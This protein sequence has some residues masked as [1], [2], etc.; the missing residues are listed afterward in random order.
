M[1][2]VNL[3]LLLFILLFLN[4]GCGSSTL[5]NTTK[6]ITSSS[7][8]N[9]I[10]S[11]ITIVENKKLYKGVYQDNYGIKYFDES[12]SIN[13]MILPVSPDFGEVIHTLSPNQIKIAFS[14]YDTINKET[15]LYV[16]DLYDKKLVWL[17]NNSGYFQVNV[18]W[19]ND[20]LLYCNFCSFDK[21]SES[22]LWTNLNGYTEL[23]N[24]NQNKVVKKIKPKKGGLLEEYIQKKYFVYSDY[25]G[26]YLIDKNKN[27][28]L[29]SW[30]NITTKNKKDIKY[31]P[32]GKKLFYIEK[33]KVIDQYGN[34]NYRNELILSNYDGSK[35]KIIIGYRYN[36]ENISWSPKSDKICCDVASQEWSNIRHL[37]IYDLPS[38]KATFKTEATNE[39]SPSLLNCAWSPSGEY[40]L[41]FREFEVQYKTYRDYFFRNVYSGDNLLSPMGEQL[42]I[43]TNYK[44][45]R[46][47]WWQDNLVLICCMDNFKLY[48]LRDNSYVSLPTDRWYLFIEELL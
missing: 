34:Y 41:V 13:E 24:V 8:E 1:K 42:N 3:L 4:C 19:D 14:F 29:R 37:C 45:L 12:K 5:S 30:D 28:L 43:S 10:E 47:E 20:S 23:L 40:V 32:D 44:A 38:D 9:K 25:E 15:K 2:I 26:F 18:F 6:S 39:I 46:T 48:N 22:Q 33:R 17:K 16:L 35:E 21:N 31:S 7:H 36:P 11:P 27:T